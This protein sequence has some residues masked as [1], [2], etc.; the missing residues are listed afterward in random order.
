MEIVDN[1]WRKYNLIT[2][3]PAFDKVRR[4]M[5]NSAGNFAVLVAG[6]QENPEKFFEKHPHDYAKI[7]KTEVLNLTDSQWKFLL[8]SY[9]LIRLMAA[10][11]E[12]PEYYHQLFL[13]QQKQ[14][15]QFHSWW[16][17]Y[18][19][20]P[21]APDVLIH[22]DPKDQWRAFEFLCLLRSEAQG[23]WLGTPRDQR[24][25][26]IKGLL[27]GTLQYTGWKSFKKNLEE[28]WEREK[29]TTMVG[30]AIAYPENFPRRVEHNGC[31]AILLETEVDFFNQSKSQNNCVHRTYWGAAKEKKTLVYR[32]EKKGKVIAT[33]DYRSEY[34]PGTEVLKEIREGN[35][36]GKNNSEAQQGAKDVFAETAKALQQH[37]QEHCQ[38]PFAQRHEHQLVTFYD[39]AHW[40]AYLKESVTYVLHSVVRGTSGNVKSFEVELSQTAIHFT[41]IF[42]DGRRGKF[43]FLIETWMRMGTRVASQKVHEAVLKEYRYGYPVP[44]NVS[45][46]VR[47]P[48]LQEYFQVEWRGVE[49]FS[50]K[51]ALWLAA[52][53]KYTG[54]VLTRVDSFY[55]YETVYR[56]RFS[57]STLCVILRRDLDEWRDRNRGDIDQFVRQI[58]EHARAN[59]QIEPG[60]VYQYGPGNP[61]SIAMPAR[62]SD[63]WSVRIPAYMQQ[64]RFS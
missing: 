12:R 16:G 31:T 50:L 8:K 47:Q 30:N 40:P 59:Q 38:A 23:A 18:F 7:I 35:C 3:L 32:V 60:T 33:F 49:D 24:L 43:T 51:A 52:P 36:L 17:E 2:D 56:L 10:R 64:L 28:A 58:H 5:G 37:I 39:T 9:G 44:G 4:E 14:F 54:A 13:L 21:Q 42:C 26:A 25:F 27:N 41:A 57:D 62:A 34:W 63:D 61:V 1:I 22:I 48:G 20:Y 19:P 11:I 46:A 53:C 45:Q 6:T 29:I 55:L 15:R